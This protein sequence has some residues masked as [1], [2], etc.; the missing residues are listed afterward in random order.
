VGGAGRAACA[1]PRP[2]LERGVASLDG[3]EG[4]NR[5]G[6]TRRRTSF[7]ALVSGVAGIGNWFV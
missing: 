4:G 7:G 3:G 6:R 1:P 2:S 5:V